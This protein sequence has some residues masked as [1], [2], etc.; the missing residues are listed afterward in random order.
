MPD[1]EAPAAVPRKHSRIRTFLDHYGS[2]V[3]GQGLVLGLGILTGILSARMLGPVGRGEYV[4]AVA[5]PAGIMTVVSLGINQAVAYHVGR[6]SFSLSEMTTAS[7]L[8][9]V[10]QSVVTI[11][12]G[13]ALLP[14][15]LVNYSSTVHY[16]GFFFLFM[17]PAWIFGIYASNLFQGSQDLYRF[18]LI[19]V[20][21]PIVY[22]AGLFGL[23]LSHRGTLSG[24]IYSQVSGYVLS[25]VFGATLVWTRLRPSWAWNAA[26]VPSLVSFGWR[27]QATSLTN[28]FN[29]RIDQLILSLFVPPQQLG[30]YAVAVTLSMAVTVFP[31]AAGIVTFSRGSSQQPKDATSTISRSFRASLLWLLAM[32]T[33]LYFLA[34]I[35]MHLVFGAAFNGSIVACRILLPGALMIGMNQVLYNGASALGRPGLP[36]CAEGVS[37]A[38][39]AVGLYVLVP[40]YGYV[41]AAIV[42]SV[43]YTV[44]FF[45]MLTLAHHLLGLRL[46]AL[47]GM[48]G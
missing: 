26:T 7:L 15:V 12:I 28:Y 25:L 14:R 9:G 38:V 19:R 23:Y 2:T 35:L 5:W 16:L 41:G 39:T 8:I 21:P 6:K 20:L 42:S 18:N 3:F 48:R 36:S 46:R 13:L 24:V 43:A 31:Y 22:F 11:L 40:R 27:T 4:A 29:Q 30:F 34:P 47:L 44:S 33:A 17:T 32:C 1:L 37:V 10:V 45:V